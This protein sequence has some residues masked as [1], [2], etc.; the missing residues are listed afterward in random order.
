MYRDGKSL[1]AGRGILK[2]YGTFTIR[3]KRTLKRGY[4]KY[5]RRLALED[6]KEQK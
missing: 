3:M 2:E 1:F 5:I 6:I 4:R